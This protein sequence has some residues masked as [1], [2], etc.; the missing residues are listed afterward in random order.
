MENIYLAGFTSKQFYL[1]TPPFRLSDFPDIT[2]VFKV[3]ISVDFLSDVAKLESLKSY[4]GR[5]AVLYGITGRLTNK[6]FG[7][8]FCAF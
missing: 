8:L 6:K 7:T 5:C 1:F 3:G 2:A 4:A